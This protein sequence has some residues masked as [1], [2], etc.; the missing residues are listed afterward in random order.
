MDRK[1]KDGVLIRLS[2][3][4][5]TA[6]GRSE[7]FNQQ[8]LP[9]KVFYYAIWA[10]E[11]EVNNGGFSQYFCN[12]SGESAGFVVEALETIGAPKNC[13]SM[14]TSDRRCLSCRLA[15]R[16]SPD[17]RGGVRFR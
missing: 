5:Q 7:D 8:A 2:E 16:R 9:Q 3:S 10:L 11:S 13:G 6:F 4:G 12:N 14:Q 15:V 17:L 1:T